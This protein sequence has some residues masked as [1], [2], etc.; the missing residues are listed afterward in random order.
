[1]GGEQKGEETG[2]SIIINMDMPETCAE[3]PCMRHDSIEG[4]HGYQCNITLKKIDYP[5]YVLSRK[6]A[7]CPLKPM[8]ND[9]EEAEH[10]ESQKCVYISKEKVMQSLTEE[11]NRRWEERG[12]KL[13]WI[14]KAVNDTESPWKPASEPPAHNRT[15]LIYAKD[16]YSESYEFGRYDPKIGWTWLCDASADYWDECSPDYWMELPQA[17]YE[18]K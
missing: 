12:L 5:D 17:P 3:C 11:Y 7:G 6:E 16:T 14:E 10:S 4:I 1:M 9:K 18:V 2:M 13:A 8:K 15:V